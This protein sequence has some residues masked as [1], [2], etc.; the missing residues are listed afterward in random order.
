MKKMTR[1]EFLRGSAK[2]A[3]AVG[4]GSLPA[5]C[6]EEGGEDVGTAEL[7]PDLALVNGKVYTIDDQLP[8]AEAF[9]IKNGRFVAVGSSDDIRN[10]VR[11][12]T[13]V[14]DAE[15]MPV[16]PGF[17]DAHCHAS[18]VSELQNVD[19]NVPSI[20]ELKE[21]MRRRAAET[22]P[23]YWVIASMYDDTK[24]QEGRP[25]TRADLDEVVPTHP[26]MVGHRGGHTAVYNSEAFRLAGVTAETPQPPDGHFYVENGELTGKVAEQA[27]G[28]FRDVGMRPEVTR[29]VR[30][31]GVALM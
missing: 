3:A 23:G 31:A 20:A 17:I 16:V 28:V 24:L 21:A 18:G 15:G 4:L 6:A 30:Q 1:S 19:A 9:A 10:L 27:R 13:E 25:I 5:A 26:A 11:P 2:L 29:E 7:A 22:E 8:E 12:G 14:I